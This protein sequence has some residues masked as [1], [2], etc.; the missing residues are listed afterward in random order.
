MDTSKA[1]AAMGRAGRGT[2]KVRG[3][4][5]HYQRIRAMRP[6]PQVHESRGEWG[7]YTVREGLKGWMVRVWSARTGERTG[8]STL[9]T[10]TA[11]APRTLRLDAPINDL[12]TLGAEYVLHMSRETVGVRV[13]RRGHIVR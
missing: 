5:E 10:Y 9:V 3:G 7:G 2:S 6:K 12:G 13:L 11:E 8:E 4:R 1:A